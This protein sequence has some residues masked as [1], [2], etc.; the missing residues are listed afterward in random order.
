MHIRLL[1]LTI[2][3]SCLGDVFAAGETTYQIPLYGNTYYS[4]TTE[5]NA[6]FNFG[7]AKDKSLVLSGDTSITATSYVYFTKGQQ[8]QLAVTAQ[9]KGRVEVTVLASGVSPKVTVLKIAGKKAKAYK[10]GRITTAVDGYV[11]VHYRLLDAADKVKMETLV[12]TGTDKKPV[13]LHEETNTYFGLRGPSC[14]LNYGWRKEG[15]EYDWATISV[16]VPEESDQEGSYYMALGFS[17]GYFGFQNNGRDRRNVLFSAWNTE[18]SD[19]PNA[20][21]H[22]HRVQ[23]ISHGEGVTARDFGNEGSGKQS[24]FNAGWQSG[25]TYQFLLHASRVD[26]TTVDYSAWFYDSVKDQWMYLSTLRRPNTEVLLTGLHSFLENF[27]PRQGDKTRRAYYHD[28]WVRATDGKW[29]PVKMAF[30]TC[31]DTGRKGKRLDFSG[32]TEQGRFYMQNGGYFDRPEEI[33]R[34]LQVERTD[35]VP[36]S[37]VLSQIANIEEGCKTSN[38]K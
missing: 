2:V 12:V 6:R 29:K 26:A 30:L 19:D 32:G 24:F 36:P 14:H 20:V 15:K 38:L 31:D 28:M 4:R 21:A 23:V 34:E 10:I 25:K 11:K 17:G 18:D 35:S 7:H 13:Y 3:F 37:I 1:L 16:T 9:G 27:D 22:E 8:P 33:T 5:S